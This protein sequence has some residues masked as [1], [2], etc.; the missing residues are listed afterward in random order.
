MWKEFKKFAMRGNVI[1]MAVGIVIGTTFGVIVKSLVSDVIM[2]P[3]GMILG[4]VDFANLFIILKEGKIAGPY[5]SLA[6]AQEAGA[7]TVNYGVFA[8][9]IV[10]F[11]IVAFAL[12]IIIRIINKIKDQEETLTPKP[13]TKDCP[14]CLS[15]IPI[16]ATRCSHCTSELAAS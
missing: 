5:A 13:T 6:I 14:Y 16:K 10:N 7:V 2:P 9:T 1:D 3:I 4:K 8:N 12:F 11:I 15:H